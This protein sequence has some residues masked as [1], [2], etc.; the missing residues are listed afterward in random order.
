MRI[1]KRFS[2]PTHIH[3]QR[4]PYLVRFPDHT[5]TVSDTNEFRAIDA[6]IP[7]LSHTDSSRLRHN[8]ILKKNAQQRTEIWAECVPM[9][10]TQCMRIGF[11][12]VCIL[13]SSTAR[14]DHE[15]EQLGDCFGHGRK[16]RPNRLNVSAQLKL[17][18]ARWTDDTKVLS[19][20][21]N[22]G[23]CQWRLRWLCGR[24]VWRFAKDAG[25]MRE[26]R[27]ATMELLMLWVTGR[28]DCGWHVFWFY[29]TCAV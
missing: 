12:V 2:H 22:D 11:F 3:W 6:I 1:Q 23:G 21:I 5:E 26:P 13:S 17:E 7:N 28:A 8:R 10:T 27:T 15:D 4:I 16:R 19:G 25:R 14:L 18:S 29:G 20:A 24:W 9:A